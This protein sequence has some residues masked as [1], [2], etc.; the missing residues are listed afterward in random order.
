[1]YLHYNKFINSLYYLFILIIYFCKII[2]DKCVNITGYD[3]NFQTSQSEITIFTGNS[4]YIFFGRNGPV[5]LL[6]SN[7]TLIGIKSI[8]F[9]YFRFKR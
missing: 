5:A 2:A 4:T 7:A 9:M 3:P 1:M 6:P 8:K